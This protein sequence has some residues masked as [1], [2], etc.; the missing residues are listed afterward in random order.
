MGRTVLAWD[1]PNIDMTLSQLLGRRPDQGDRPDMRAVLVWLAGLGPGDKVEASVFVNV[2]RERLQALQGWV[3]FLQSIGYRVFA[4]PKVDGSDIDDAMLDYVSR[5][6]AGASRLVIASNDARNFVEAIRQLAPTVPVT[7]LGFVE[8]AGELANG[9][10]WEFLDL[11][12]IP[13]VIPSP[14]NRTRLDG[15]DEEGAWFEPRVTPEQALRDIAVSRERL[16]QQPAGDS[17]S[18]DD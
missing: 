6:A 14:L 15:L 12:G 2:S 3:M 5:K 18:D 10:E 16:D 1:A 11:E 9:T 8:L 13:G 7:V 4:R 17:R